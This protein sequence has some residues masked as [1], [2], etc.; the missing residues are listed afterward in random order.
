MSTDTLPPTDHAEQLTPHET[1]IAEAILAVV[2]YASR[3]LTAAPGSGYQWDKTHGLIEAANRLQTLG[4]R[5]P[6]SAVRGALITAWVARDAHRYPIGRALFPTS[7]RP[8]SAIAQPALG[9]GG[10][11]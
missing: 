1:R 4:Y 8:Q 9:N 10:A 7:D 5:N 6:V 2:D 3:V 11:R